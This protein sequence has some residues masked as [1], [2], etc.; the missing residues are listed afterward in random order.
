MKN[1]LFFNMNQYIDLLTTELLQESQK[2]LLEE[3]ETI[4]NSANTIKNF[5]TAIIYKERVTFLKFQISDH[6]KKLKIIRKQLTSLLMYADAQCPKFQT[7]FLQ[8]GSQKA[9][10]LRLGNLPSS[11]NFKNLNEDFKFYG[12]N[13]ICPINFEIKK[14]YF[15]YRECKRKGDTIFYFCRITEEDGFIIKSEDN[16]KE[17]KGKNIL[18]DFNSEFDKEE[19]KVNSIEFFFLLDNVDLRFKI[20]LLGDIEE[21]SGYESVL[22]KKIK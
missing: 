19:Q 18:N 4:L 21:F 3:A 16:K 6:I 22:M 1:F 20:E 15:K 2:K 10:I 13:Y 17:W 5:K 7:F 8:I 12:S 14:R 11:E 9:N